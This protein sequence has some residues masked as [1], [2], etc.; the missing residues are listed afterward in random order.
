MS[1]HIL[2][3]FGTSTGHNRTIRVKHADDTVTDETVAAAMNRIIGSRT[4]ATLTA[5]VVESMRRAV[6]VE[7]EI[8]NIVLP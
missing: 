5:G 1:P 7:Q 2:L 3:K 6:L 8:T 4:L